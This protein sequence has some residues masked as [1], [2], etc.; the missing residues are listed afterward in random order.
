MKQKLTILL[1]L[2]GFALSSVYAQPADTP[3]ESKHID[4]LAHCLRM[5]NDNA[6]VYIYHSVPYAYAERF[7]QPV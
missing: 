5:R 3:S 1:A 7:R 2:T 4:T 6:E